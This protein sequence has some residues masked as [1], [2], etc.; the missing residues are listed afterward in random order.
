MVVTE[1][2]TTKSRL[3]EAAGQE[4]A[5]K[6]Y[7][8]A[9][10][11][12]IC[13]RVGAN[14]AAVN[15]HFGSKEQLYLEALLEAHRCGTQVIPEEFLLQGTPA[16]QLARFIHHFLKNVVALAQKNT[17]HHTLMLREMIQPTVALETLVREAIRPKFERLLGILRRACPDVDDR[18]LHAL[19]FSVI[20]QCLH[21]RTAGEVNRRL[22]GEDAYESLDLEFL[23]HH[24]SGFCLAALGLAPP[25]V[26]SHTVSSSD[27]KA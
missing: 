12:K 18:R 19:A 24:I 1:A 20:G 16:E 14:C 26:Q 9:S 22:I 23:S 27:V 6:G 10:I 21:Y 3:L 8:A 7:D 5:Q 2:T 13:D 15:Y 11:R 17:W 25:L 4:F